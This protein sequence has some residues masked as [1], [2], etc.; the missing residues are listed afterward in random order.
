MKLIDVFPSLF[1]NGG[2]IMQLSELDFSKIELN[3]VMLLLTTITQKDHEKIEG[4]VKDYKGLLENILEAKKVA[5][6]E[7]L[8]KLNF[9]QFDLCTE[10]ASDL[11]HRG[12]FMDCHDWLIYSLS[13]EINYGETTDFQIQRLKEFLESKDP[14][15]SQNA[16]LIILQWQRILFYYSRHHGGLIDFASSVDD[17]HSFIIMGLLSGKLPRVAPLEIIVTGASQILAWRI[18]NKKE[19]ASEIAVS[20]A[21]LYESEISTETKKLIAIQLAFGGYQY[22]KRT[23]AEWSALVLTEFE[24]LLNPVEEMQILARFYEEKMDLLAANP[25]KLYVSIDKYIGT[26]QSIDPIHRKYEKARIFNVIT[27]VLLKCLENGH[28]EIANKIISRFY[29]VDNEILITQNQLYL[30]SNYKTG[31]LFA[32]PLFIITSEQQRPYFYAEVM[33]QANRFLSTNISLNDYPGFKLEQP[34]RHGVP[35]LE[36]GP[37]FENVIHTH[38]ELKLL[39]DSGFEEL[40]SMIIIPGVQHPIQ[41]LM[42]KVLDKTLPICTSF[43]K[44][45]PCRQIKKALLW[46]YGTRTSDLE[47]SLVKKMME[48]AGIVVDE[49]NILET[50][51]ADFISRYS[52]ASYDLIWVG[53]HG[54]FEHY[55]P[56]E[57]KIDIHPDGKIELREIMG[58]IPNT[59]SQRLLFL[60]ICDGATASTLNA[61]YD[62]GF[63]AS[64]A[65]RNQAVLSHIWPIEIVNSFIYG[66]LFAHFLI[67]GNSFI[68]A[69]TNTVKAFLKGKGNINEA[70]LSYIELDEELGYY[71]DKLDEDVGNN[72]YYWSSGAYYQ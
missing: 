14:Y 40:D 11:G 49:I 42:I 61:V 44:S 9:L 16:L 2:N 27:G 62:I 26:I 35:I 63:G 8:A 67:I 37:A 58:L 13:D 10:M 59:E 46:C 39:I 24:A 50:S 68:E 66:V 20:L 21:D 12:Q 34:K 31:V 3:E 52:S 47:Y 64:L 7:E 43:E 71:L 48:S 38:Y 33:Q 53:T 19:N 15:T 70:L 45:N 4:K 17:Y 72:I 65:N 22:T 69:Y 41:S 32:S 29:E 1:A 23:S 5:S 56:H 60:N 6:G 25:D 36:E 55:K 18:N 30:I 57:S 54:E 28:F 51:K